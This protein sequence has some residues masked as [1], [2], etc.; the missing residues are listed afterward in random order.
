MIEKLRS[1]REDNIRNPEGLR[2]LWPHLEEIESKLGYEEKWTVLEQFCIGAIDLHDEN[3][4]DVCLSR[5]KK[6]FPGSTRVKL[7]D[8]MANYER[9]EHFD[10]AMAKYNEILKEDDTNTGARKRKIA[11]LISRRLYSDAIKEL[12]NYLS[13]F[14]NDQESWKELGELYMLE[15]DYQKA[16]FCMEEILLSNPSSPIY[17]TRLAELHYT[18]GSH[19][20]NELA[21]SYYQQALVFNPNYAR[22]LLGLNLSLKHLLSSNKLT[23]QQRKDNEKLLASTKA[24]IES[25][26]DADGHPD[27]GKYVKKSL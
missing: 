7:L 9:L 22:A 16:I 12:C 26:Y 14:M 8:I 27:A 13:K 15:H 11:I 2:D 25:I 3:M 6:Q 5:L 20:S 4:I 23:L 19:E 18:V 10:I 24:T 1:W 21:S 17:L